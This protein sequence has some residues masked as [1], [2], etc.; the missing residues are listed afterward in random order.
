MIFRTQTAMSFTRSRR[1]RV[2]R[3]T[4]GN[5]PP[6][7]GL[8]VFLMSGLGKNRENAAALIIA[9]VISRV[10]MHQPPW[11]MLLNHITTEQMEVNCKSLFCTAF[12][13][14]SQNFLLPRR[15]TVVWVCWK[16][17]VVS[18]HLILASPGGYFKKRN[19]KKVPGGSLSVKTNWDL[20]RV[21][22][23]DLDLRGTGFTNVN[24]NGYCIYHL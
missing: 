12:Y 23:C 18:F 1:R 10:R 17:E 4:A 5:V 15:D 14:W 20:P 16:E 9:L 3:R 24:L 19:H 6:R 13:V 2:L 21:L 7:V 22:N 8:E 11:G